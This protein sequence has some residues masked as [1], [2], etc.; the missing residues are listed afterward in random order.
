LKYNKHLVIASFLYFI[1]WIIA[2]NFLIH[3]IN[4]DS[5][6]YIS[7]SKKYFDGNFY[8]AINAYWGPL[9]SWIILPSYIIKLEPHIFARILFGVFSILL[10]ILINKFFIKFQINDKI[11]SLGIYF[12]ILPAIF[13]SFYRLTPDYLLL[14]LTL[15]YVYTTLDENFWNKKR[16]VLISSV[17]GALMFLT[18]SY[19]LMFFL[20]FQTILIL[21]EFVS[22][23]KISKTVISHYLLSIVTIL[24]LISPWIYLLSNKYGS[25][26]ISSSG[27]VNIRIVNPELNF[28]HPSI[29]SGFK[30]PSYKYSISA[31]DDPD[32][33]TY[34]EWNPFSTFQNLKYFLINTVKNI[35][36]LFIFILAFAPLLSSLIFLIKKKDFRNPVLLKLLSAGLIYGLGYTTIYVENRYIWPSL[37]IFTFIGLIVLNSYYNQVF[38]DKTRLTIISLLIISSF[39]PFFIYGINQ[40]LP[41][42]SA[43]Y[44]AESIKNKFKISGNFASTNYWD[45]GLALTY[46]LNSKFYGT[47]KLPID[48]GKLLEKAQKSGIN[49]IFDYSEPLTDKEGL[50][51]I[52]KIDSIKIYKVT[53][54][55]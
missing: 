48:S 15:L 9:F 4:P 8:E 36:K 13:F 47:E 6:S 51:F 32:I 37:I 21:I 3:G 5:I 30:A 38:K 14:I 10:F 45:H 16:L 50:N 35:F 42:A 40:Q 25:F 33:S 49:Y 39:V 44:Q 52:G 11:K 29:E 7:I 18:K 17:L 43:Y 23:K 12:F 31:W 53:D 55:Q 1:L 34:P 46:F 54:N 28:R 27:S 22:N 41:T 2:S 20:A 19:G 24:I 26:T